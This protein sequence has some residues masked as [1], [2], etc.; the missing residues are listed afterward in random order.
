MIT[1]VVALVVLGHNFQAKPDASALVSK[2]LARYYGAQSLVGKLT[3]TQTAVHPKER[4]ET[5][6]V[7][8]L[9]YQRPGKLYVRQAI[10]SQATKGT[11]RIVSDGSRFLYS[12][13][14]DE[15]LG[16]D[17][18]S[19]R[20]L[21]EDVLQF[22]PREQKTQPLGVGEI[23]AIGRTGLYLRP[24]PLDVA[25]GLRGD[26]ER[27]KTQLVN[28]E[29]QGEQTFKGRTVHVVGGSWRE[30]ADAPIS[31]LYQLVL[32]AD[33]DLIRYTRKENLEGPPGQPPVAITT[34]WDVD[35]TIGGAVNPNLFKDRALVPPRQSEEKPT[36]PSSTAGKPPQ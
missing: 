16:T 35:L 36:K 29:D 23:Y 25:I 11:A 14:K 32:T 7:T 6:G 31:G 3:L 34:V 10:N 18:P 4:G 19:N 26:L 1:A 28:V 12:L 13:P 5:T 8:D 27:F 9:Q 15:S 30:Y 22:N 21:V 20:E 24:E 17:A 33:G 2:M